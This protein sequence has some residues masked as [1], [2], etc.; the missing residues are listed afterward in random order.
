[1]VVCEKC[2][3]QTRRDKAVFLEKAI[4]VN[5]LER[6]DVIQ[7]EPY[8][9]RVTREVAY[10]PSCGKHGRIYE[11]KARMNARNRER[12]Q[13]RQSLGMGQSRRPTHRPQH[14]GQQ[15]GTVQKPAEKP[16]E[17]PV[18]ETPKTEETPTAPE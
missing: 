3:R 7:G 11:K 10:C 6:K 17:A 2:G 8:A 13:F 16:A 14:M 12:E 5:P 1:M 4:F 15:F 9:P 18:A